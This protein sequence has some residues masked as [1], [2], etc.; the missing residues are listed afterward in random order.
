MGVDGVAVAAGAGM[1][2][3]V[4]ALLGGE[5]GEDAIVEVDEGLQKG[6]AGPGVTGVLLR[7]ETACNSP[8]QPFLFLSPTTQRTEVR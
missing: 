5:A 7:C 8:G 6:G 2:A 1:D 3:N 4:L